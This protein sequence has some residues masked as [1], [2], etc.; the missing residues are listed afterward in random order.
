MQRTARNGLISVAEYHRMIDSGELDENDNIELI[1][2]RLVKKMARNPPHDGTL[3]IIQEVLYEIVPKTHRIRVQCALTT[4]DSE[5]E[6]D[7][8]IVRGG[9]RDFLARHPNPR[10]IALVI[11]VANTSVRFDQRDKC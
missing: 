4:L 2:G 7:F 11:E 10:D 5:P 8:A 9:R 3:M 1:E 6:P